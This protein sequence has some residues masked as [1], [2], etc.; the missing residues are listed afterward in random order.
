MSQQ[1]SFV[2]ND[3]LLQTLEDLKKTFGVTS[4]A[5]VVRKALALAQVAAANASP[6]HTVTIGDDKERCH[7]VLLSG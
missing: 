7:K 2:V 3:Q 6:D 4:N 1:I 5:A